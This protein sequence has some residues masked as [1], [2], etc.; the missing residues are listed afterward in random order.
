MVNTDRRTR[1][2]F[3]LFALLLSLDAEARVGGGQ[4][5]GGG[6]SGGSGDSGAIGLLLELLFRFLIWLCWHHPVIG[7]PL[8][9]VVVIGLW[10]FFL[11]DGGT[12]LKNKAR[13]AQLMREAPSA[14]T[15]EL[16]DLDPLFSEPL[17]LDYVQLVYTR[18]WQTIP[19]GKFERLR[20]HTSQELVSVHG[21]KPQPKSINN[22]IFG[23]IKIDSI[24]NGA[25]WQ[26][27]TVSI[28]SNFIVKGQNDISDKRLRIEKWKFRRR[29]GVPSLG[30]EK[31]RSLNCPN[32]GSNLPVNDKGQCQNCDAPRTDGCLQWEANYLSVVSD[33]R[34]NPIDLKLGGGMEPGVNLP[35]RYASDLSLGLRDFISRHPDWTTEKF[36]MRAS[37]IF[38]SLQSS[39]SSQE[40]G[41]SRPYQSDSLF[42]VHAFWIQQ[43]K[44]EKMWNKNKDPKILKIEIVKVKAD[45]W[46]ESITIRMH[47]SMIDWT[48]K[49]GRV[50]SG[51]KSDER[52]FSEYWTFIR[53]IGAIS[54]AE[55]IDAC[56]SCGAPLDNVNMS[57]ICG[58][59]DTHITT[60][61]FDWVLSR[62]EQAEAYGG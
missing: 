9:T 27:I 37:H 49:E 25:R 16:N 13:S 22:I 10:F 2:F 31:L 58:Y 55:K 36:E 59:C 15:E 28:L 53:S 12:A 1:L 48:E 52:I 3:V 20:A 29:R 56:P 4:S 43:Y 26:T 8:T 11:K 62:I 41:K 19:S 6:G 39:W 14:S 32:C 47:A 61:H 45:S 42:K 34:L 46:L 21:S 60:G 51:S 33:S 5:F 7:I 44:D 40:W 23:S 35:T 54:K 57:G 17:F 18:F 50:I 38:M 24:K 30:P